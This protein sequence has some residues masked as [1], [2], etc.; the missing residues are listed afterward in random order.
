MRSA[1]IF[2]GAC[3]LLLTALAFTLS[4]YFGGKQLETAALAWRAFGECARHS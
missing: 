3:H 4:F 1:Q 2:F